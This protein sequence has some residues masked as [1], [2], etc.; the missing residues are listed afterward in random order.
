MQT[1][2]CDLLDRGA[3]ESTL[4]GEQADVFLCI[5]LSVWLDLPDLD[6]LLR[7]LHASLAP[8]G[9]LIVDNFQAHGASRFARDLEMT[10]RY[11]AEAELVD[12][13]QRSGFTIERA[14]ETRNHVNTV[15]RCRKAVREGE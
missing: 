3:L 6:R 12:A 2:R 4:Q 14:R 15:Y 5:G 9:V 13:L 1:A 7:N 8:G 10:P 11:R